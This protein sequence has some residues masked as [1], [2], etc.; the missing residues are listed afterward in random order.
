MDVTIEEIHI[1]NQPDT[2]HVL[3]CPTCRGTYLHHM[4][5]TVYVR[6]VEDGPDHR[7]HVY[8][9]GTH[10]KWDGGRN[11]S[12]RRGGVGVYFSCE[13]CGAFLQL[14]LAQHKGETFVR[15][16]VMG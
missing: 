11:P 13:E 16:R 4:D 10:A 3:C 5:V 14:T 1:G 2:E 6:P 9:D 7:I 15:W 8:P 12:D